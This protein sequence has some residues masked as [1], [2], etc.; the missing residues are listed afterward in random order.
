MINDEIDDRYRSVRP[1]TAKLIYVD[2]KSK[3]VS[4]PDLVDDADKVGIA[5]GEWIN[6]P[7]NLTDKEA[8]WVFKEL[9]AAIRGHNGSY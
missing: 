8:Q 2:G 3:Q 6:L 9:G 4:Y 1:L 5:S 7:T